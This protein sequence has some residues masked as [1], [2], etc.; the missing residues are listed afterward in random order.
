[1]RTLVTIVLNNGKQYVDA[2]LRVKRLK[3]PSSSAE[4][5]L[6]IIL[7][8][9]RREILTFQALKYIFACFHVIYHVES[10]D[11]ARALRR[12]ISKILTLLGSQVEQ[13]QTFDAAA[14]KFEHW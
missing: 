14:S 5:V 8:R 2:G 4:L 7:A 9:R 12:A 6:V 13:C 1:M 11:I 10:L 3:E